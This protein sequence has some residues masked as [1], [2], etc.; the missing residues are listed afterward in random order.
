[1]IKFIFCEELNNALTT[2]KTAVELDE[3]DSQLNLAADAV[4]ERFKK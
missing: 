1:M 3:L 4:K 2:L